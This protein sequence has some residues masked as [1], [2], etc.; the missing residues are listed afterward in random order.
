[1]DFCQE[2]E[3]LWK[4]YF[5]TDPV[6]KRTILD[7]LDPEC[8]VIGTGGD[9]LYHQLSDFVPAMEQEFAEQVEF[10][11]KDFWCREKRLNENLYLTYGGIHIWWESPDQKILI[12]MDS[13]YTMLYRRR[14]ERWKVVHIHHSV[15]NEDQMEGE[16]Y[17]KTLVTQVQEAQDEAAHMRI[18]AQRDGLTGLYNY[19]ALE[20]QWSQ[21]DAPGSWFFLLDIDDFKRVNDTFD[22]MKGNEV[23]RQVARVMQDTVRTGDKV[24]RLGGDEF[25]LLCGSIG[26]EDEARCLV[27]RLLRNMNAA[28]SGQAFW[29]GV[30]IG[31][32]AVRLGEALERMLSRA[33][34]ALYERKRTKKN[35]Y[36]FYGDKLSG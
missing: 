9:E 11:F 14:G 26:S 18:L 34:E 2:T 8:V 13:R 17:P 25:G 4:I 10:Q 12:D 7:M 35:G 6:Q 1:M 22:H 20:K 32:T 3:Q 19:R 23:L 16:F 5:S 27:M 33:D 36:Q 28:G 21:W 30:S 15:P 29:T 31:G 24:F